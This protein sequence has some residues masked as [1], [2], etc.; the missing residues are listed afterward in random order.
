MTVSSFILAIPAQAAIFVGYSSAP[1]H[2][3]QY[4]FVAEIAA[5]L[6]SSLI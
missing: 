6:I 4:A 1:Q 2:T 5:A 3:L